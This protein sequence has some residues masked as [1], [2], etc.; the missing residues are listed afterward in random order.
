M[1]EIAGVMISGVSL[2]SDLLGRFTDLSIWTEADL[3]VDGEYLPLL[4][5]KAD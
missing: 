4:L 3:L 2:S 5:P 1:I